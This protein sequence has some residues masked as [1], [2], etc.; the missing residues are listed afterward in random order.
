MSVNFPKGSK[1]LFSCVVGSQ[2]YGTST[3]DS[4]VDIKG[5]FIPPR[6]YFMGF[7][8]RVE[9][10]QD[11]QSDIEYYNIK[12]FLKIAL[13]CNP[14]I[15]EL[16]Y[17]PDNMWKEASPEWL[18]IIDHREDFL[19]KRARYS[20]TGYAMSQLKKIKRHRNWLLNPPIK[21]PERKDFGLPENQKLIPEEQ[22]GAFN[23]LLLNHLEEVRQH[24]PLK[25]EIDDM[26]N[27]K[28]MISI[29]QSLKAPDINAMKQ[30]VPASDNFIMAL[31]KEKKYSVAAREWSQYQN[32]K[33]NR[34]PKRHV[35]EEKYGFDTKHG[36]H[37]IRLMTEGEELMKQHKITF[38]RP[39]KEFLLDIRNGKYSYDEVVEIADDFDLKFNKYYDVSNLPYKPNVKKINNLCIKLVNDHIN[40]I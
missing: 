28:G 11:N 14:T 32:W 20:F 35:L 12:K 36:M 24:H 40:N 26:L 15:I 6:Q 27:D 34:N 30:L 17:A 18:E 25:K 9:Q 31:D 21:K 2:L 3:P 5:V 33:K 13:E 29:I 10:V 37:L 7:L 38:P 22:I 19:S 8:D 23:K 16:L 1:I 4:D 39:D